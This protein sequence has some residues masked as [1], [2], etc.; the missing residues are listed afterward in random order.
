[1]KSVSSEKHIGSSSDVQLSPG[2]FFFSIAYC[3]YWRPVEWA[4]ESTPNFLLLC[5]FKCNIL[6][7]IHIK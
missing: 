2:V 6:C 5:A 1:L 3:R 4:S 7:S